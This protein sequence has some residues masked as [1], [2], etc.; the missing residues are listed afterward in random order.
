MLWRLAGDSREL[1]V[2]KCPVANNPLPIVWSP[3][4]WAY[5]ILVKA[6]RQELKKNTPRDPLL[7]R[8]TVF[9]SPGHATK[10][11][12]NRPET[13]RSVHRSLVWWR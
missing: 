2:I 9:L 4:L 6:S 1:S 5:I 10:K 8:A 11:S 7:A 12:L 3:W 13:P